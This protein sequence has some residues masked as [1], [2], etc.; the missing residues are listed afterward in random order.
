MKASGSSTGYGMHKVNEMKGGTT[1]SRSTD[2]DADGRGFDA[3]NVWS[4][5]FLDVDGSVFITAGGKDGGRG[6]VEG[7]AVE[8]LDAAATTIQ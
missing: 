4:F 5:H 2:F 8:E 1:E 3:D 7:L 6:F